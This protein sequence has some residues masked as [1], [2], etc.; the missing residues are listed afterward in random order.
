MW[1][2]PKFCDRHRVKAVKGMPEEAEGLTNKTLKTCPRCGENRSLNNFLED[3]LKDGECGYG[4]NCMSCKYEK[5]HPSAWS[6]GFLGR[7]DLDGLSIDQVTVYRIRRAIFGSR[8]PL[9]TRDCIVAASHWPDS[10]ISSVM[11]CFHT[12]TLSKRANLAIIT[13]GS[14]GGFSHHGIG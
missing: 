6:L 4:K 13:F 2:L 5:S 9:L 10:L 14:Y 8:I 3:S 1:D 12:N 11:A 7:K